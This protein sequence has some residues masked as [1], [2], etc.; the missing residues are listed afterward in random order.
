MGMKLSVESRQYVTACELL[1]SNEIG[2][3]ANYIQNISRFIRN[4]RDSPVQN[5][6]QTKN[7][8]FS[9]IVSEAVS[10]EI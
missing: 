4:A 10:S 8:N 6:R 7:E 3:P 2:N 5:D 9:Y 1:M